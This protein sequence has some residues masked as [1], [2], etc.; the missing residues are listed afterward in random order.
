MFDSKIKKTKEV[1]LFVV[2][3]LFKSNNNQGRIKR[4]HE[5]KLMSSI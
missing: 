3:L 5:I 2:F 4:K 1:R